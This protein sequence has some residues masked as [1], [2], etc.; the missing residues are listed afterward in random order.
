MCCSDMIW[1]A[2]AFELAVITLHNHSATGSRVGASVE[3]P[4]L[5]RIGSIEWRARIIARDDVAD[6]HEL[7]I[8]GLFQYARL[9]ELRERWSGTPNW[10]SAN[11]RR[12]VTVVAEIR[13]VVA[14]RDGTARLIIA[15]ALNSPEHTESTRCTLC[16]AS[17]CAISALRP[18]PLMVKNCPGKRVRS[19]ATRPVATTMT[20]TR[21]F[22]I[23]R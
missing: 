16:A 6:A 12:K 13:R 18:V 10:L 22:C 5:R 21:R 8:F 4:F 7:K 14:V 9:A 20:G 11:E 1:A 19:V 23:S 3:L 2:S 15:G 17:V